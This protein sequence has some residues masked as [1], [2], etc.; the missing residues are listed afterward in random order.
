M[1][2]RWIA[3]LM[4]GLLAIPLVHAGA[5]TTGA[6]ESTPP[7]AEQAIR[8]GGQP[9]AADLAIARDQGVRTVINLRRP[10]EP[11]GFDEPAETA[12]LGLRYEALPFRGPAELNDAVFD[13]TRELLRSAPKPI[14]LHCA[15]GN[16]ASAVWLPWR[17]LDDGASYEQALAE[18]QQSGLTSPEFAD[19]ARDYIERHRSHQK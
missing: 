3:A 19:K 1:T 8:I 4:A 13:R 18:A 10:D 6:A 7:R 14:L 12:R 9:S 17:V 15:S 16:R 5:P 11:A 2:N